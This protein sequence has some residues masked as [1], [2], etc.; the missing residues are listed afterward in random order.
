M[1]NILEKGGES[2]IRR[3]EKR[4]TRGDLLGGN[5]THAEGRVVEASLAANGVRFR[6]QKEG[7]LVVSIPLHSPAS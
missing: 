6:C 3:S 2:R 4:R 1:R 7:S 5:H